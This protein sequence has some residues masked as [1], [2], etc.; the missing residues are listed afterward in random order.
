MLKHCPD[1]I[2]PG[3]N[4][5]LFNGPRIAM[6]IHTTDNY[7]LEFSGIEQKEGQFRVANLGMGVEFVELLVDG[8]DGGQVVLTENTWKLTQT[9]IPSESK[10]ISLGKHLVSHTQ[11]NP[12]LLVEVTPKYLE[13]REFRP[14]RTIH[15]EELGYSA[16]PEIS[17][18][19][20]IVFTSVQKPKEVSIAEHEFGSDQSSNSLNRIPPAIRVYQNSIDILT[21]ELRRSIKLFEGYES[22]QMGSGR[23][24]IAFDNLK[25]SIL[26]ACYF[27]KILL[28]AQW[29]TE[30]LTYDECKVVKDVR[31]EVV[32]GRGLAI[33]IGIAYGKAA[34]KYWSKTG[35]AD[36]LGAIPNLAARVQAVTEP[37][38]I[39]VQPGNGFS[40]CRIKWIEAD[41]VGILHYPNSINGV[42]LPDKAIEIVNVGNF[43]ARGLTDVST[44]YQV[45]LLLSTELPDSV[46]RSKRPLWHR[47]S[48]E[49]WMRM[50]QTTRLK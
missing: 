14:I 37:G 8:C 18:P 19:I 7:N 49:E 24:L 27:Q 32:I 44:L 5:P 6:A 34:L 28:N 13:D 35:Q 1:S 4:V 33:R 46:T 9:E 39:L 20:A 22:K 41:R 30:L 11:K 45:S 50:M 10:V 31:T 38:Q 40:R 17:E 42:E 16:S 47:R 12:M 36:Y 25:D 3:R 15:Q 2:H 43:L 23:F 48:S 21:D 26:W 29:S